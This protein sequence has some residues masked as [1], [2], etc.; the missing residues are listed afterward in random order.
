MSYT[1]LLK[2]KIRGK[3]CAL[4]GLGVSNTPLLS[5]LLSFACTSEITVYDEKLSADSE[6][7][8]FFSERGVRF[9]TGKDCFEDIRADIIFRSPGIRPDTASIPRALESGAL[10]TS[11][12]EELLNISPARS[13]AI[14]GSDGK[15]T[16]TT[17]C[18]KF[19]S[20][21]SRVF[22][23]GNIGTPL[24]DRLDEM[25]ESDSLVLEL[26]SFQLMRVSRTPYAVAITNLSQNHLDWHKDFEEYISAKKNAIGKDTKR[27]VLNADCAITRNIAEEIAIERPDIEL[28]VFSSKKNSYSEV[29]GTLA[30]ARA[31]FIKDGCIVLSDGEREE[32]MLV[33]SEVRL[34]GT[35]NLENYM[36]AICLCYG[37]ARPEVF[38]TV[39][40]EFG[41]VEHRLEFIRQLDG[42]DYYNSS[43]DSSPSRTAAALSALHGRDITVICGG[44]D[45]NL[46]YAPLA[47]SISSSTVSTVVLT[48]NTAEKIYNAL[49]SC[50]RTAHGQINILLADSFENALLLARE[51][52]HRGGCVLLSPASA[53]FDLF[54]NFAERGRYFKKLVS[55]LE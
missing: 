48:G 22:V 10:L 24:L 37:F 1:D 51:N 53:S 16:T 25:N 14:T 17:L 32:T 6:K 47:E 20:S 34:P 7:A 31:A 13:F 2:E 5:L 39:A 43:I 40:H 50:D 3:R 18:G 21:S 44:Y 28:F 41:G 46:D 9:V 11:E 4:L 26:S 42:V 54:N 8:R 55:E 52:A 49:L 29:V 36:T 30:R 27:V 33:C 19:L 23:G 45:K 35:H 12:I 38:S 15:T